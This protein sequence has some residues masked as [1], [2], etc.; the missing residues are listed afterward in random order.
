MNPANAF[1]LVLV[2]LVSNHYKFD[3]DTLQSK[4]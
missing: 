3:I 1:I 2:N 4:L